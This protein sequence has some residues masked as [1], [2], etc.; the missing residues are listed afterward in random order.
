MSNNLF[1]RKY[2]LLILFCVSIS[3]FGLTVFGISCFVEMIE[4]SNSNM[5][6]LTSELSSYEEQ[7]RM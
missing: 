3:F 5:T 2:K 7:I 6:V 1:L 4:K